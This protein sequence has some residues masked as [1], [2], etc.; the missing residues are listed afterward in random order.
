M[1]GGNKSRFR[2][3][4][5]ALDGVTI[6]DIATKEWLGLLAYKLSGRTKSLFPAP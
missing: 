5:Y 3:F 6:T 1:T 2:P 4:Y